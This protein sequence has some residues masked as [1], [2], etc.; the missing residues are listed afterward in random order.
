MTVPLP[1]PVHPFGTFFF[2]VLRTVG[3]AQ[4]PDVLR[5]FFRTTGGGRQPYFGPFSVSLGLLSLT[6]PNH[7][8]FGTDVRSSKNQNVT[9][10]P[11]GSEFERAPLRRNEPES[12]HSVPSLRGPRSLPRGSCAS[13]ACGPPAARQAGRAARSELAREFVK[14]VC[15]VVGSM[16][17]A[18][19]RSSILDSHQAAQHV[20]VR[21]REAARQPW[22]SR[23]TT[24]I[25][26]LLDC[27]CGRGSQVVSGATTRLRRIV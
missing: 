16:G 7:A 27:T 19:T 15:V 24:E 21:H 14:G 10:W 5:P 8:R 2:G 3:I 11:K 20:H 23:S 1:P 22:R 17:S 4:N 25:R 26:E 12:N 13:R 9:G 6:Q 18:P